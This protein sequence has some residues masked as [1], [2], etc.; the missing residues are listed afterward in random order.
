MFIYIKELT[1]NKTTVIYVVRKAGIKVV[2]GPGEIVLLIIKI[3]LK[4]PQV[5]ISIFK[6]ERSSDN[7]T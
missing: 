6:S 1:I 7:I 2:W 3:Q 4:R 5:I